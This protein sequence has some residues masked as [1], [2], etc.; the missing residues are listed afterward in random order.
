MVASRKS[1]TKA[2]LGEYRRKRNFKVTPE[3]AGEARGAP[4]D[5]LKF[6]VQKHDATRL[7]YDFRL[8]VGGVL[9]S[10]AVP[11][12]PSLDPAKKSLAV[13]VEDHPLEY[14][15][16]EGV[17]P[18]GQYGG[19]TVMLWDQGTWE[20]RGDPAEGLKAGKL[21]FTLHGKKLRGEWTL[22]RMGWGREGGKKNWLLMK[23]R[24][25]FADGRADVLKDAE[26]VTSGRSMAEI[27]GDRDEVWDSNRGRATTSSRT[28]PAKWPRDIGVQLA[29]LAEKP[30]GGSGWVHEIKLDGYRLLAFVADGHVRLLT[31]KKQDWTEKFAATAKALSHIKADLAIIDGEAV[32][33]DKA[34][35]SNFQL[36]QEALKEGKSQRIVFYAFD[37][38]FH[39][40]KDLRRLPLSRR[41]EMLERLLSESRLG[42]RV[43]LSEHMTGDGKQII[44]KACDMSLEG[45][46]S[47]RVD[48]PYVARRDP[49]WIKSKCSQRQE[50]V[51]VGYTDPSG[52]REGFGALLL[53]Y[54]DP[55][56]RLVYAGRVGTGFDTKL[57]K[58]MR[59]QFE[60]IERTESALDVAPP[61][62]ERRK[63]HWVE[64]SLVAEVRFTN[65]TR[66]GSLRHPTFLG[67]R[68]D[69]PAE[70]VVRETPAKIRKNTAT[71]AH[72]DAESNPVKLTHPDKVLDAE[73]GVTKKDL[74]AYC[75]LAEKW[76]LP[77]VVDRPLT[78]LR[79]PS[80]TGAKCFYQRNWTETVPAEL[81][82]N[83]AKGN[84]EIPIV[85]HDAAGLY[86]MVQINA[87]E[88]HAWNC[89]QRDMA[90]PD[91]LI[92]DLDPGPGVSWKNVV[93]GAEMLRRTL[94][95]LKLPTF[96]KTSGGKG[97]HVI[98]P[99]APNVDWDSA[100]N[101]CRQ[102]ATTLVKGSDL[103]VAN[104]RKDLRGG[105]IYIDFQRNGPGATAITPYCPRARKGMAV[106][107]P[108][109]W[110]QLS[111]INS[112]DAFTVKE[113]E[114]YLK[115]RKADPW[116]DF[117]NSRVDLRKLAGV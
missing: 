77:H 7:H 75:Q 43:R 85:I 61:A 50:M 69:K 90:H 29:V 98:T 97:L 103:F 40:G 102:I 93:K 55:K 78:L 71:A 84:A 91:Q 1:K 83:A 54:H 100:K 48:A 116:E 89:T 2:S 38:L 42:T 36:L 9:K 81:Q 62:R 112:A 95:G 21:H 96:I 57:L 87:I 46:V 109:A 59:R 45:I 15:G 110:R 73:S 26:S 17:I 64:P 34:G 66:D 65:W 32:V 74:L 79:C 31:R 41:K 107:M 13:E 67:L 8:E 60:A 39:N 108:I 37:L 33:L 22:V 14:G 114:K 106:A 18:K 51:I 99:I 44:H 82:G 117:E 11:K 25:E 101:F 80:G 5:T 47:K 88:I 68:K 86:Q 19:G 52:S 115:R 23:L 16:F 104:M 35:Q 111:E 10:W 92:F 27:A 58:S 76:M 4:R 28:P 72:A 63:A 53:G 49:T 56:H 70:E 105:K 6:V 30:P 3:P 113:A 24:D 94:E 12:G 20:P